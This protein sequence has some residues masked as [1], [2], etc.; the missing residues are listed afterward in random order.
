MKIFCLSKK[1]TGPIAISSD[2]DSIY[3]SRRLLTVLWF[4]S[5]G[6][7]GVSEEAIP[8]SE[9]AVVAVRPLVPRIVR[10]TDM[11]HDQPQLIFFDT[12]SRETADPSVHDLIQFRSPVRIHEIRIIPLGARVAANFPNGDRLG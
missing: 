10:D 6:K 12:F 8:G 5:R 4:W 9:P 7:S 1:N 3:R 2:Y 11:D